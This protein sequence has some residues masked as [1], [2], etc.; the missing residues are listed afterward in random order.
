MH[1]RYVLL[2]KNRT[3]IMLA[4]QSDSNFEG[5]KVSAGVHQYPFGVAAGGGG[6]VGRFGF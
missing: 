2:N 1:D 5:V 3:W 6:T 4:N